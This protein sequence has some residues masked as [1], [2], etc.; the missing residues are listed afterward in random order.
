MLAAI[1]ET[2]LGDDVFREDRTTS[3]FEEHVANISGREDG[4]FVVTGTMANQLC[5][6][7]LVS[8]RPCGILLDAD[9]HS[10]NFEGGGTSILSG[11][12]P[13]PI[14]PSNGKYLRVEDLEKHAILTDD[15]HKCPTGIIS[16][17]NTAG[18]CILPLHELRRIRDWAKIHGVKTHLD[19]ARLFE[20]VAA[21]AGT[22]KEYCTLV[23][24][25]S[26]DFSKNLGAPM[27]AMVLG[28]RKLILQMR[29]TRKAIGGGMRQGGVITAAAREAL[30]ENF[31]AGA[32]IENP[33]LSRVHKL[34]KRIG[35]EWTKRG[36]KL[37]KD[38]ETNLVW[39]D[40]DAAG[41][42]KST[43][44]ETGKKFNVALDSPRIVCHHQIDSQAI[45]DLVRLFAN[46]LGTNTGINGV[47]ELE[48]L[49]SGGLA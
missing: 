27:G 26:V 13:Q 29:R 36:G 37:S 41:I 23:D 42:E 31:G 21:G 40:I 9:S 8:T 24:L 11:A 1:V 18:G 28:D 43:L 6:H 19:G 16:M 22:L 30:F 2:T 5:L 47:S 12:M 7:A 35:E 34:A 20:A 45:R 38:V 48:V 49:E 15:V 3:D 39:L 14:K 33:M 17:E 44:I 4:M 32:V 46:L 25:V 10:I